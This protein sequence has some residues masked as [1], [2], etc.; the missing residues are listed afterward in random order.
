VSPL[1]F[2]SDRKEKNVK[3]FDGLDEFVAA[4]GG[5]L[6]PTDWLEID[7]ESIVRYVG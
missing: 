7:I 2:G 5:Q 1:V 6:G 4:E 3:V